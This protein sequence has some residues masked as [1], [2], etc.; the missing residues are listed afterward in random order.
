M[1]RVTGGAG[2]AYPSVAPEFTP[3]FSGVCVTRSNWS[4]WYSWNIAE[5]GV[6]HNKSNQIKSTNKFRN[7][8]NEEFEDTKGVIRIRMSATGKL[9][10]FR[11]RVECTLVCYLQNRARTHTVLVIDLY[12]LLGNP[13]VWRYQRGNQNPHVEEE[14]T[15]LKI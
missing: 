7:S 14:Q 15:K 6:K 9:Y 8:Y 4:P 11:L 3:S 5:S 1:T 10:R 12:E 2:N 13:T